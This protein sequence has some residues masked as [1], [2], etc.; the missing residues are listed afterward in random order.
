[1]LCNNNTM[2]NQI[3][4]TPINPEVMWGFFK[5]NCSEFEEYFVFNKTNYKKALFNNKIEP[6]IEKIINYYY[7]SKKYF[8]TRKMDYMKF[9]TVLRQVCNSLELKYKNDII[10]DKSNYEIT[11]CFYK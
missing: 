10:Y 7:D 1:M 5:E 3:F 6:F 4:K 8:V 11:Y 2:K 9:I